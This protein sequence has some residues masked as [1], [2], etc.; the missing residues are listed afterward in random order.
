ML[1]AKKYEEL[2]GGEQEPG[3]EKIKR[4]R[5]DGTWIRIPIPES[6]MNGLNSSEAQF[7]P[8]E[9]DDLLDPV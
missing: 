1:S 8:V 4:Q 2:G 7:L 3:W 5:I 6:W 9:L